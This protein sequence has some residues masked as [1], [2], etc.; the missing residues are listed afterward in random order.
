MEKA[1]RPVLEH[2]ERVC[3]EDVRPSVSDFTVKRKQEDSFYFVYRGV[4]MTPT[5]IEPEMMTVIPY[6]GSRIK[7]GDVICYKTET[8]RRYDSPQ[9][10]WNKRLQD[11]DKGR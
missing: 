8:R 3:R 4:S 10:Y 9:N 2:S 5:F 11:S 7:K 6:A 1:L